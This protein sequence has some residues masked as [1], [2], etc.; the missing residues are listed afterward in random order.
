M[1]RAILKTIRRK[2]FWILAAIFVWAVVLRL[3]HLGTIFFNGDEPLFQVRISYQPLGYVLR[4][5]SGPLFSILVHFLLPLGRLEVMARLVSFFA[6]VLS[7]LVTYLLGKKMASRTT[8]WVAALFVA[9][10]HLLIF[11][12]QNSRPYALLTLLSLLSTYFLYKAACDGSLRDW[13]LY[14]I[15]LVFYFYSHTTAF[16]SLPAFV[17]FIG[18]VWLE[19]RKRK[20]VEGSA[21]SRPRT[22]RNFLIATAAAAAVTAVLYIPCAYVTDMLFGTLRRGLSASADT[23]TLSLREI[24][25]ILQLEISPL[26]TAIF[27]LTMGF[28]IVGLFA[29]LKTFRRESVL[30]LGAIALP[31]SAFL[32]GKPRTPD[33]T[34]LYRFLQHLLPLIFIATARGIEFLASA[35][36]ALVARTRPRLRSVMAGGL[37]AVVA[38]V[39]AGGYFSNMSGYY[40]TDYWREGAFAFDADVK[41]YLKQH[42]RRDAILFVD[43]YPVSSTLLTMNPLAQDVGPDEI[44]NE[45]REDYVRPPGRGDLIIHTLTWGRFYWTAAAARIE[46]WAVTPKTSEKTFAWRSL[47]RTR[48]DLEITDLGKSTLVHFKKDAATISEK[49]AALADMLVAAPEGDAIARRQRLLFAARMYFMTRDIRDGIRVL[50]E[51]EAVAVDGKT[52][53]ANGGAWLDRGLGRLLGFRPRTIRNIFEGRGLEEIQ[54]LLFATGNNLSDA[55]RLSEAVLAFEEVLRISGSYNSQ[56]VKSLVAL[57]DRLEKTGDLDQALKAWKMAAKLDRTRKDIADRIAKVRAIK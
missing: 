24:R 14:G 26:N 22:I 20:T 57:G 19:Q 13:I 27:A 9:S 43:A 47:A 45:I 36:G 48:T 56:A 46:L 17:L 51:F 33:V 54:S 39:L 8:G 53:A 34:A 5:N 10:G 49:M 38:V 30:L 55:G 40:Y 12:S 11:Y 25:N 23:V 29:R 4:Y 41:A 6:G 28:F 31:W 32:L 3:N 35:M 15:S 16:L 52:E 44:I 50:R 42:A 1:T 2:D 21:V 37:C 7:V 18:V